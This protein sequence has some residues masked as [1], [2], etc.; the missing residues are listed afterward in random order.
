MITSDNMWS[1][2]IIFGWMFIWGWDWINLEGISKN[3]GIN[4]R[5]GIYIG[6]TTFTNNGNLAKLQI[7][8][9]YL[10]YW[11]INF[12]NKHKIIIFL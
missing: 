6:F 11:G 3:I 7:I 8:I 10:I 4:I 1:Y 12:G 2:I 9:K 5:E